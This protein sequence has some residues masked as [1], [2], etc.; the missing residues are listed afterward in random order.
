MVINFKTIVNIELKFD[1][2]LRKGKLIPFL[3][4]ILLRSYLN[5]DQLNVHFKYVK[6]NFVPPKVNLT[7]SHIAILSWHH[8]SNALVFF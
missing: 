5:S 7:D 8:L 1:I 2:S 3:C 4:V 6:S